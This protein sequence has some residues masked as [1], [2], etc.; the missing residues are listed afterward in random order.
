MTRSPQ[1]RRLHFLNA[2]FAPLTGHDLYL[3]QQ[4]DD[5][6]ATSIGE[7]EQRPASDPQFIAAAAQLF[8]RLCSADSSHGFFHWDAGIDNSGAS[9][10]FARAGVM[11]GLKRLAAYSES[12][13][14]VTNL[15]TAHCPSDKR[16]TERR[17]RE[18]D[19]SL[20][21]IRDLAVARSRHSASMN[22]LF[23]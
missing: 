14:L 19:D 3:A 4:I 13:F 23:L 8:E 20:S 16:W 21:L 12:T 7:V 11:Q 2:L 9:P 10:L 15:R 6:I 5:A 17:Q 1:L 18:Y 22:L